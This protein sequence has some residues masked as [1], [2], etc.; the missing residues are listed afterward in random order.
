[1]SN[2]N[3]KGSEWIELSNAIKNFKSFLVVGDFNAH[4]SLW[5]STRN[6]PNGVVIVNNMD[7]ENFINIDLSFVS[8]QLALIASW[9]VLDDSWGSDHFPIEININVVRRQI[10]K[11]DYRYKMNKADWN[12]LNEEFDKGLS[13][14]QTMEYLK[15]EVLTRYDRF[16]N[17]LQTS[18]EKSMNNSSKSIHNANENK[19]HNNSKSRNVSKTN[20]SKNEIKNKPNCIWWNDKCEKAIRVRKA[21]QK[22]LKYRLYTN[23]RIRSLDC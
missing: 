16:I 5:E 19:N 21:T 22:S 20:S 2:K 15:T 10:E 11:K 17:F 13:Q 4:H 1:M 14:F 12:K 9:E 18:I 6:C 7:F 8:P 3:I 23:E